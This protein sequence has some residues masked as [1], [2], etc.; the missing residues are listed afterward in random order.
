MTAKPALDLA[1]DLVKLD[2]VLRPGDAEQAGVTVFGDADSGTRVGYDTETGRVFIDRRDSGNVAFHPAFASVE[3][4]P[5]GLS[6]QGT[7]TLELYLDR[8]SIELFTDDGQVT[9]T[10][11]VFPDARGRRHLR[12]LDRRNRVSRERHGD[13]IIP[14]MW[15]VPDP[16]VA[17]EHPRMSWRAPGRRA[18]I[19]RGRRRRRTE[20]HR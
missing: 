7:V 20:E 19:C 3:D 6:E 17:R 12:L 2:V 16:V 14:S 10:D 4:A 1:G 15:A 18:S 11:Q 9:I 13:A 5:V 8:A